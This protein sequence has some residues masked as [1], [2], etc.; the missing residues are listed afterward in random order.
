MSGRRQ[1]L[2][3][4]KDDPTLHTLPVV[5]LTGGPGRL[6]RGVAVMQAGSAPIWKAGPPRRSWAMTKALTARLFR[7]KSMAI[8]GW[9]K[10]L[11]TPK[12]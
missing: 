11:L 3:K 1:F 8:S 5:V 10:G 7:Q 2:R 6:A 12:P 4:I 9:R